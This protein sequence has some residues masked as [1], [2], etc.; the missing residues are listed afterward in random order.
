M[1]YLRVIDKGSWSALNTIANIT[2]EQ[3]ITS[4]NTSA[5]K[6]GTNLL[7]VVAIGS[8][9]ISMATSTNGGSYSAFF[10]LP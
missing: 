8:N 4:T 2:S 10:K 6:E 3:V 5:A 9:G 7:D 1:S